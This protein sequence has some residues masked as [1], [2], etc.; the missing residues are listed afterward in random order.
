MP[1]EETLRRARIREVGALGNLPDVE[2]RYLQRYLPAQALY[3]A[4]AE[5]L[6]SADVVVDNS[7]P[8]APAV[9]RW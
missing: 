6:A 2:Q 4:E 3:R 9:L 5:P 7:D 8:H 1:P